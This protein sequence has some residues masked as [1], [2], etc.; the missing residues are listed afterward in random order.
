MD[1]NRRRQKIRETKDNKRYY[2]KIQTNRYQP[3][4]EYQD[5]YQIA[6]L[7]K[8]DE[9]NNDTTKKTIEP[10]PRKITQVST[11]F[12]RD[13]QIFIYQQQLRHD[14][15]ISYDVHEDVDKSSVGGCKNMKNHYH[16]RSDQ[17]V[18]NTTEPFS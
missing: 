18:V 17:I 3:I 4:V 6:D 12:S 10:K 14:R 11:F 9:S 13:R 5:K 2:L 1:A 7:E 16:V 8:T 15:R